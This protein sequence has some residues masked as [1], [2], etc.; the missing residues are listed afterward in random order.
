MA[1]AEGREKG[2]LHRMHEGS[3]SRVTG[4][5]FGVPQ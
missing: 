4:L 2:L 3:G 5:G 1:L